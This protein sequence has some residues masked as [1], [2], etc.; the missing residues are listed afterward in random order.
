MHYYKWIST[1]CWIQ[2]GFLRPWLEIRS[3]A[4][5]ISSMPIYNNLWRQIITTHSSKHALQ[6]LSL[7]LAN[8]WLYVSP[9]NVWENH[10]DHSLGY[11]KRVKL[12]FEVIISPG[13]IILCGKLNFGSIFPCKG[14]CVLSL[15]ASTRL[16][17]L[18]S[19]DYFICLG[20]CSTRE[21]HAFTCWKT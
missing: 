14:S 19:F 16:L 5:W 3:S 17:T 20:N 13:V 7:H 4:P 9:C 1:H 8:L 6:P 18:N 21:P 11:P 2:R 12:A 15:L 10:G